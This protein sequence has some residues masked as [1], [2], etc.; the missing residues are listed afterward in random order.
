MLFRLD[1]KQGIAADRKLVYF[2]VW[3]SGNHYHAGD[4]VRKFPTQNGC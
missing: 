1:H 4:D 3:G 2:L